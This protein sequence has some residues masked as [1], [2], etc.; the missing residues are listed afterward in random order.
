MKTF[1]A[2]WFGY[3]GGQEKNCQ[4]L[5]WVISQQILPCACLSNV[6]KYTRYYCYYYCYVQ[7]RK[8]KNRVR[9][10]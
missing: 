6:E 7:Q 3:N 1:G 2:D 8:I 4:L 10:S 5:F 9:S